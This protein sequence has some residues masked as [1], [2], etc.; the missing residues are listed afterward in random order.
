ML[1]K[2]VIIFVGSLI[3]AVFAG[4]SLLKFY[5]EFRK[6]VEEKSRLR[7]WSAFFGLSFVLLFFF[8]VMRNL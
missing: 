1:T 6:G 2:L 5:E 8:F 3:A 7:I 4:I